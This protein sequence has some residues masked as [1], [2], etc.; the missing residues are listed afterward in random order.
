MIASIIGRSADRTF[1]L[2]KASPWNFC[3]VKV[4][5]ATDCNDRLT[6]AQLPTPVKAPNDFE[7]LAERRR[8]AQ[9]DLDAPIN[10]AGKKPANIS[11]IARIWRPAEAPV[12]GNRW[13]GSLF[14]YRTAS[15]QL[16]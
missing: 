5:G 15:R 12:D 8:L 9:R 2:G 4:H 13:H 3:N 10:V 16:S 11:A 7:S 14:L 1:R 6:L